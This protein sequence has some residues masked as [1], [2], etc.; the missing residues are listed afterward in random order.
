MARF[1]NA[2]CFW[3]APRAF[4]N[5]GARCTARHSHAADS[6]LSGCF[7][8]SSGSP[9][10]REWSCNGIW[11]RVPSTCLQ[12]TP[13]PPR[14][15]AETLRGVSRELDDG[16]PYFVG[17]RKSRKVSVSVAVEGFHPWC[18]GSARGISVTG[19]QPQADVCL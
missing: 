12:R 3:K 15:A 13:A 19:A 4:P 10:Q 8:R 2:L 5:P 17:K 11:V 14:P 9:A 1:V 16:L 7:C 18:K 6:L